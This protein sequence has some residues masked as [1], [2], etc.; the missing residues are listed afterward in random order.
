MGRE[1]KY[2]NRP[3]KRGNDRK[4]PLEK[5]FAESPKRGH[6]R[7]SGG[8]PGKRGGLGRKKTEIKKK[9]QVRGRKGSAS[10]EGKDSLFRGRKKRTNFEGGSLAGKTGRAEGA[11]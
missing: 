3:Q 6:P 8:Q 10:V 4:K 11:V 7:K 1:E 9:V 2:T 5:F